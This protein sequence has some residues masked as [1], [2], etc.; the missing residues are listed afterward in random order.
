[1]YREQINLLAAR[2]TR[3]FRQEVNLFPVSSTLNVA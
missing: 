3:N 2:K 1:M